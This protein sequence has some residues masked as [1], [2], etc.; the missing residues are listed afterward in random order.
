MILK[1]LRPPLGVVNVL[2]ASISLV[3]FLSRQ[4]SYSPQLRSGGRKISFKKLL[5]KLEQRKATETSVP[6]APTMPHS[7]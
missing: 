2:G 4:E 5:R 3:T 7:Q 1:D 6:P